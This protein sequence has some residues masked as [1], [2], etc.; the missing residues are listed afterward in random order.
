M[1]VL[2]TGHVPLHIEVLQGREVLLG[3]VFSLGGRERDLA[4]W[5]TELPALEAQVE[6]GMKYW[7]V[8]AGVEFVMW[9]KGR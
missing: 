5:E 3:G 2:Q 9:H 1:G 8:A 4:A 6:D 7:W